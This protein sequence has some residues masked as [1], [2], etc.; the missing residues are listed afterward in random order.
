MDD[1]DKTVCKIRRKRSV[2]ELF[3]KSLKFFTIII[4]SLLS[5]TAMIKYFLGINP[6]YTLFLV[7]ML[8]SL[9]ATY[10]KIMITL[11]PNF[12]PACDCYDNQSFTEETMNGILNLLE[13]KRSTM[14]FNIPNS[15]YGIVFY[16]FMIVA[17]YRDW[18]LVIKYLNI[19][20]IIGSCGL[21]YIM[22][23]EVKNICALCTTIH[24]V[25]FLTYYYMF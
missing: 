1:T 6:L 13:H 22:I 20:S 24:A 3:F 18:C 2:G 23:T 8:C 11:D 4:V 15:V 19:F 12:K 16:G 9:I 17:L 14:L 21:W 10:Y 5:I 7:G 25:N